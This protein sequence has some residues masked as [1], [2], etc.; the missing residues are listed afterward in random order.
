VYFY[1]HTVAIVTMLIGPPIGSILME[2]YSPQTAYLWTIPP[3]VVSLGLLFMIPETGQRKPAAGVP[4][5]FDR[6]RKPLL[7]IIHGKMVNLTHHVVHNIIPIVSQ[8]PVLLGLVSFVVNALAIPLLGLVM[9]YMSS[10]FHWKLSQGAWV[11]SFQAAVQILLLTT[12]LPFVDLHLKRKHKSPERANLIV[13]RGSIGFLIAGTVVI[14]LAAQSGVVFLGV[15]I[16]T[17]GSGYIP[18]LRSFLTSLVPRDEIALLFTMISVF[19]SV[20]A[21]VGS[22]LLALAFSTGIH[23]GGV[24]TGL[25]FFCAAII[26]AVS[27]L[28]IW[29]LKPPETSYRPLDEEEPGSDE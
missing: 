15:F 17:C 28:S 10:K 23:K 12:A 25:P 18:A 20:G 21:L 24:M 5:A 9:Q 8:T 29:S 27:A 22:P 26:Y 3:R 19:E 4:G 16:Y 14:G 6:G 7:S 1:I 13:S 2:M 11:L